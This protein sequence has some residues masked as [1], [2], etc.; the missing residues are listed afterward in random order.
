MQPKRIGASLS[1]A[2][3]IT[4]NAMASIATAGCKSVMCDR[5]GDEGAEQRGFAEMEA[6]AQAAGYSGMTP[7]GTAW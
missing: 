2:A 1:V 6:A 4:A 3:Q 7:P 5:P